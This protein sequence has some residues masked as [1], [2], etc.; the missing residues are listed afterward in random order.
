[1][2]QRPLGTRCSFTFSCPRRQGEAIGHAPH[3]LTDR[4]ARLADLQSRPPPPRAITAQ[5][6][7]RALRRLIASGF[8]KPLQP[9]PATARD[10]RGEIKRLAVAPNARSNATRAEPRNCSTNFFRLGP[11]GPLF[12]TAPHTSCKWTARPP[13]RAAALARRR[14]PGRRRRPRD[15][16][17]GAQEITSAT[18]G[19]CA[20]FRAQR[21][22]GALRFGRGAR[23]RRGALRRPQ[24]GLARALSSSRVEDRHD[25]LRRLRGTRPGPRRH[26]GG[27]DGAVRRPR[28]LNLARSSLPLARKTRC[29]IYVPPLLTHH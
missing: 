3:A 20:R 21:P 9:Q 13:P 25:A 14:A 17:R 22:R 27:D 5:Q 19:P 4:R 23:R 16:S 24:G 10:A 12:P 2:G 29:I 8:I 18:R 7:L 15:L 6:H 26:G 28:G 11:D 1:M